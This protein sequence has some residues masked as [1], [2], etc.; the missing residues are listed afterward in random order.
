MGWAVWLSLSFC[1]SSLIISY[2]DLSKSAF[3]TIDFLSTSMSYQLSRVRKISKSHYCSRGLVFWDSCGCGLN[4]GL[5][6]CCLQGGHV[7]RVTVVHLKQKICTYVS[8][9]CVVFYIL[10][11]LNT[12]WLKCFKHNYGINCLKQSC[13]GP[14]A[15]LCSG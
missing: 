2:A 10:W 9:F 6:S 12:C 8:I 5:G 15:F 7:P 4:V 3:K 1:L 14:S 11:G 13:I